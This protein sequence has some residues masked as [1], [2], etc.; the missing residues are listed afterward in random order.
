MLIHRNVNILEGPPL[1]EP[2]Q[3][4]LAQEFPVEVSCGEGCPY[5]S[6]KDA[7]R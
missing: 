3:V 6:G 1:P 2:L 7:D 5:P 4:L